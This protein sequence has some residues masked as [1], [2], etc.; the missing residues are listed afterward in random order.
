MVQSI[1]LIN[2]GKPRVVK[3][4]IDIEGG[5][6]AQVYAALQEQYGADRVSKVLT[7]RT[8]KSKSALLTA[9]R[10][11]NVDPDEAAYIA[12]FIKSDRGQTRT[13]KQTF[14][15]DE[16]NGIP[17]DSTF[18]ELMT[19]KYPEVWQVAQR[20]E[21]LCC[22]VGSHAGGV[23]FYDEPI[24]RTNALMQTNNGDVITQY[25][26][27]TVERTS[28]LKI[29][30]LS[31]EALDRIRAALDLLIKFGYLD[32]DKSLRENY[33][34]AIG[35]YKIERNAPKMWSMIH[36][37]KI[38]SLF[39]MEQQSGIKGIA[40]VKP[41]SVDDLAAL[42]AVIRLMAPE[43]G[44][45]QPIDKFARFKKNPEL[46]YKE[47]DNYGVS[48]EGQEVL[49]SILGITYGLCVQQ[50]QFMMLVQQPAIGGFTLLWA[51]R[52]RKAISR[53][54]EH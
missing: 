8:E 15:G 12:S 2:I 32:K 22:G 43:K 25:D 53:L 4:D 54:L 31:I 52:L 27:H 35:V 11:L 24:T 42:N 29:D 3:V 18:Q 1:P 48:K 10:G 14:Y 34:E 30:L 45:E 5:K 21:N 37:H 16:E 7:I 41:T 49:K 38:E 50:E 46:W 40:A 28:M 17:A 33:E 13:L 44:A 20:I 23:V 19:N 47:M 9:C 36:E 26:L 51:D 6:R 39:Q